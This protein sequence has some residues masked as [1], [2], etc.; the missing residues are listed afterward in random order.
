M[1]K[2]IIKTSPMC[3]VLSIS[4]REVY[5]VENNENKSH[6][7]SSVHLPAGGV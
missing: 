4:K 6:V 2:K 7:H 5:D 3:T 1:I